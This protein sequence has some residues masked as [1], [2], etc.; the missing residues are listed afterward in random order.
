MPLLQQLGVS[1]LYAMF[2]RQ[3]YTDRKMHT[4]IVALVNFSIAMPVVVVIIMLLNILG[5]KYGHLL[6]APEEDTDLKED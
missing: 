5:L 4:L 1:I 6:K 3:H 2:N